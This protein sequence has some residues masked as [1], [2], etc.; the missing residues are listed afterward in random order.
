MSGK[1]FQFV[2]EAEDY[3]RSVAFYSD[4]LQLP[5]VHSWDRGRDRGAFFGAGS[6]IVEVVSDAGGFRGPRRQGVSIEADDP[7]AL[8]RRIGDTGVP[9]ALE[10]TEQPWGTV[11]FAVLDPDGN[12][13]TFFSP[14]KAEPAGEGVVSVDAAAASLPGPWKP[15][16]L[17]QVNDAVVRIARLAGE[18]PWH[19]HDEDELFL[20]VDGSF[21]IELADREPVT[22]RANEMFVVPKGTEHRPVAE[23]TAHALLLERPETK[24]YGN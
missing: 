16:D 12:A 14:E 11:E 3:D 10:L 4:V 17:V 20:C 2:F 7:P 22:L 9:F 19:H 21:Q 1:R 8:Y 13:V 24:Q 5:V 15:K 18:F 23:A 6:G